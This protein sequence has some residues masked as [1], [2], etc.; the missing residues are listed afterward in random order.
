MEETINAQRAAE[1]HSTLV[2]CIY[3]MQHVCECRYGEQLAA[4]LPE[5]DLVVGFEKYGGLA[6]SLA[7]TL[8]GD[9]DNGSKSSSAQSSTVLEETVGN[10]A[11]EPRQGAAGS[12]ATVKDDS[13]T[14]VQVCSGGRGQVRLCMPRSELALLQLSMI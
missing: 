11:A 3:I 1:A 12:G 14:R 6:A 4:D 2:C 7:A 10:E 5:A 8:G 13:R 9:C